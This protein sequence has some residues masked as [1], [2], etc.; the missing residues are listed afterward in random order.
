MRCTPQR[1]LNEPFCRWISGEALPANVSFI[2]RTVDLV[3]DLGMFAILLLLFGGMGVLILV[4]LP[5]SLNP[6][7]NGWTPLLMLALISA[8]LWTPPI[9]L[10]RRAVLTFLSSRDRKL[11]KLREGIFAGAEGLLVRMERGRCYAIPW[12]R[13]VTASL[14][15]PAKSTDTRKPV[16]RIETHG[17]RIEFFAERLAG[18]PAEINV[19]AKKYSPSWKPP[20]NPVKANRSQKKDARTT[21]RFLAVALFFG[22]SMLA[23]GASVAGAIAWPNHPIPQICTGLGLLMVLGSVVYA[24]ITIIGLNRAYRCPQCKQRLARFDEALPEIHYYCS[25]CNIEW[26]TGLREVRDSEH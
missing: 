13:F 12:D 4:V 7:T 10:A 15:P 23:F 1:K 9:L 5:W 2:P 25:E 20:K 3:F 14:F 6:Q 24:F 11:G 26:D 22:L 16:V 19:F 18:S 8:V 17:G 21:Q